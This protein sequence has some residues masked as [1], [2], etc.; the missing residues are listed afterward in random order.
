MKE[1]AVGEH[2]V[3]VL[4][5]RMTQLGGVDS[6]VTVSIKCVE[7]SYP[8]LLPISERKG[9]VVRFIHSG[10]SKEAQT[11]HGISA[12]CKNAQ[13]YRST[14]LIQADHAIAILVLLQYE[15][16]GGF[17]ERTLINTYKDAHEIL[18]CS[19]RERPVWK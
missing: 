9:N 14:Y 1:G 3:L 18:H 15:C 11:V 6:P 17:C 10:I 8:H 2:N 12:Y 16:H 13:E 7:H 5:Q 19:G 4:G